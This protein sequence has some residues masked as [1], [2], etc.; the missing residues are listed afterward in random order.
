MLH[1][2]LH[3]CESW[4]HNSCHRPSS[5][6]SN[7]ITCACVHLRT[8]KVCITCKLSIM[9]RWTLHQWTSLAE[10]QKALQ[11]HGCKP[12]VTQL[13]DHL[14]YIRYTG[15]KCCLL[16]IS[17]RR[18]SI[19]SERGCSIANQWKAW[20]EPSLFLPTDPGEALPSSLHTRRKNISF[21]H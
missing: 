19:S 1:N 6:V 13:I 11:A 8:L 17:W 3:T 15:H 14:P 18:L 21:I 16:Y 12:W 5:K 10:A 20:H 2:Q 4:L 9:W 7:Y